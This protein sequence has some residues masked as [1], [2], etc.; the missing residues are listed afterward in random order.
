LMLNAALPYF[1][2]ETLHLCVVDPGVGSDRRIIY[3]ASPMGHFLAPDNGVLT[4]VFDKGQ[5]YQCWSV[6]N[7]EFML[8]KKSN[9]FHGRDIFAPVAAHLARGIP[10][11]DLGPKITDPVQI[12]S[13]QVD[14][15]G[16]TL[17]GEVIYI[18]GFGNVCTNIPACYHAAL[19][20][21][22]FPDSNV[23]LQGP[24]ANSYSSK[25]PGDSLII[26]NSFAYLELAINQG[27]AAKTYKIERGH[28]VMIT[29]DAWQPIDNP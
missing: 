15:K 24:C 18:D 23:E 9:T 26:V 6:T 16:S 14:R 2:A 25:K 7:T 11:K 27:D 4:P 29:L 3:V 19:K 22:A 21:A 13:P 1:S 28:K 8:P 5:G 17:E 10:G 20:S 12:S